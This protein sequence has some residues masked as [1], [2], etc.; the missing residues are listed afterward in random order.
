M[1]KLKFFLLDIS[2]KVAE[3]RPVV[4]LFGRTLDKKQVCVIDDSFKPYLWVVPEDDEMEKVKEELDGM[5]NENLIVSYEVIKR[6]YLGE[7]IDA[8]KVFARLPKNI[9]VIRN[10][11][12]EL[13]SVRSVNEYDILYV[14]RYLIDKNIYPLSMLEAKGDFVESNFKVPVF[15][16]ERINRKGDEFLD[17]LNVLAFDIEVYNPLGKSFVPE[18]YPVVMLSLYG[19]DFEKVITWKKFKT[20]NKNIEFVEGEAELIKRFVEIVEELKPDILS[21][22]FSDGFD[23]PYLK[24]RAEKCKVRLNIGVDNSGVELLRDKVK[25]NGIIHVDIFKFMLKVMG[26]SFDIKSYSLDSVASELLGEKKQEVD[27]EN[28]ANVW[29]GKGK[30]GVKSSAKDIAK[31]L[32]RYCDYN[33]RDSLL[34]Y[35]LCM[36][37]LPN[38][39]ELVKIVGLPMFDI[40]RMSFSQLVEWH[41]I[42]QSVGFDIL[43]PNKPHN[44]EIRQRKSASFKGAF[45][46]EPKPGLYKDIVIY[47]YKS[48]Y[49]TIISSHNISPDTLNCDCCRDKSEVIEVDDESYWFCKK[50]KG[51]IPYVIEDI[52]TRRTRIKEIIKKE[53][54][55]NPVLEARS[56]GL[57]LLANSMYGYYGF[58]AARWYSLE[59]AKSVTAYGRKY[60][61]MVIDDAKEEGFNVVYSDTDSIFLTMKGKSKKNVEHF[62]EKINLELPELMELEYEGLYPR[63]LFV[64]AKMS[65]FGAKKKYALLSE[66]GDIK[67]K[68]FESVRRNISAIAKEVQSKVFEIVLK[69]ENNEKALKY[70]KTVILKLKNKKIEMDKVV[71][72]TQLTK[73]IDEYDNVSPHVAVALRMEKKKLPVGPGV[74]V[75]Y[76]IKSGKEKIS[77]RARMPDEIEEDEYDAEYYINNQVLPSVEKIFEVLGYEK[78]DIVENEQ[79]KL[80]SFFK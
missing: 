46:Y 37:L 50:K 36:K 62:A 2:Y 56:A 49:P 55:S 5:K 24:K 3:G 60:I 11:L 47:D 16:A 53:K 75:R 61:N 70:V 77:E 35:K 73:D 48:L 68:G 1:A 7:S 67:V 29:D 20:S 28:L 66:K 10:E 26:R 31:E 71:I 34:T 8:V 15:K 19:K 80:E 21:G 64:S 52:I 79:S 63:G 76:V 57:K 4:Y 38:I 43:C 25:V 12:K 6:N 74:L 9:P 17:E 32:E 39:I 40:N 23:F 33:L 27:I 22:Y 78:D 14:N 44:D 69:E 30:E 18:K 59:C 42:R 45:V 65:S 58:F 54:K 51:F 41:L 72:Q 13:E